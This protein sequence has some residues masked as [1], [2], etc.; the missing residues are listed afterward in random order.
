MHYSGC[1]FRI[2]LEN[3]R[4]SNKLGGCHS[5]SVAFVEY[6]TDLAEDLEAGIMSREDLMALWD[7]YAKPNP[8]SGKLFKSYISSTARILTT[9]M[10]TPFWIVCH[11]GDF[12]HIGK[13]AIR[14]QSLY[15]DK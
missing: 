3:L 11:L 5:E 8:P 10:N 1:D 14:N 15:L 13:N 4:I 7:A 12:N 6:V 9:K 2:I